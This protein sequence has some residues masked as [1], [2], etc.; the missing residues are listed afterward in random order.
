ML[1][2]CAVGSIFV[3]AAPG[4]KKYPNCKKDKDCQAALGEKCVANL[5][6]NCKEDS[7]CVERTPEGAPPFTCNG[8]RC[9]P[10]PT[11]VEG[12]AGG[13]EGDPCAQRPDCLGGLAC[14]E[15]VCALCDADADCSPAI[16]NQ[17]SGR[18]SPEGSCESDDQC[19]I[20]EI[21]DGGMCVFSG[22]LGDPSGPCGLDAVYFAFDSHVVTPQVTEQIA[23]AA[24]CMAQQNTLVYLEAHADDRGT[25]EYNIL[26][27]ENRGNKIKDMLIELGVSV[28]N[29]Q[30]IAK[31]DLEAIGATE[32]DRA[33]DRRVQ[34]IW[35]STPVDNGDGGADGAADVSGGDV[36]AG[37]VD[38]DAG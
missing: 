19:A 32:S 37:D 11:V 26:L 1:A 35:S 13:E 14:K 22:D 2:L 36:S 28:A 33:K 4:C 31:G 9:G 8:G 21:C 38:G 24:E 20:D 12:A 7:E 18:C 15:G 23:A 6:Q 16:C 30:V 25:E 27:T 10:T 17:Y 29:L 3:L 34:F 5:C